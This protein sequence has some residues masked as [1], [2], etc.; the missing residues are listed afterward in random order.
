MV[1]IRAKQDDDGTVGCHGRARESQR[2]PGRAEDSQGEPG[3]ARERQREPWGCQ[4]EPES[5][6]EGQ[7]EFNGDS[8][9]IQWRL[10]DDSMMVQ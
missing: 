3:R 9:M 2:E 10:S 7:R 4:G 5:A 8:I 1:C 6:E